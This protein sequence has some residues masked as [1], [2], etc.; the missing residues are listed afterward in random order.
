VKHRGGALGAPLGGVRRSV[1]DYVIL[2]RIHV[3]P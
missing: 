2:R 3:R 1:G